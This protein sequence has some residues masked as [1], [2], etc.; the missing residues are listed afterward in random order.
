M[1]IKSIQASTICIIISCYVCLFSTWKQLAIFNSSKFS[2]KL[3]NLEIHFYSIKIKRMRYVSMK[4]LFSQV[5]QW[6]LIPFLEHNHCYWSQCSGYMHFAHHV[7]QKAHLTLLCKRKE[8]LCVEKPK[9]DQSCYI[10]RSNYR[11]LKHKIIVQ[12]LFT[13]KSLSSTSCIFLC[14]FLLLWKSTPLL[15]FQNV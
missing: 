1:D 3:K 5:I 6:C 4:E 7:Q 10:E 2:A 11:Y 9:G 13:E 8:R 15:L 12:N 14:S